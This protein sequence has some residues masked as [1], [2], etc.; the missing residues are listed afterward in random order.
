MFLRKTL[1]Y[2]RKGRAKTVLDAGCGDGNFTASIA[3][4]G[5]DVFGIDLSEGG[6]RKAQERGTARAQFKVASLYDDYT[7][8]FAGHATFDAVVSVEV[9][10]HLYSPRRFVRAA[11]EVLPVGGLVIVTTPY[12]GYWKNIALSVTNRIDRALTPLWDGGHI[13][14]WSRRTICQLFSEL[15]F[16]FVAFEGAGRPIPYLWNG[17]LLVFRKKG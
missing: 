10:E 4:A 3:E 17:M 7:T 1:K 8:L 5:F 9:I 14:H 12:W 11:Y 2:L 16:E 15:P 6:I 13:K